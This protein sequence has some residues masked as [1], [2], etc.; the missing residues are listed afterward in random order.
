MEGRDGCCK[1]QHRGEFH[2]QQIGPE[3]ADA[4][5]L[6]VDRGVTDTSAGRIGEQH[7]Q[8]LGQQ[9]RAEDDRTDP[10][11]GFEPGT[12][13]LNRGRAQ[14]QHHHHKH[15]Q[16]H[17]RARIGNDFQHTGERRAEAEERH[18]YSDQRDDQVEQGVHRIRV[19]DH[20]QGGHNSDTGCEV[21]S[22]FHLY[23][24][25]AASS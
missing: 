23:F 14:V 7:V 12:F 17:D 19:G 22:E 1:Q 6:G 11:A 10:D 20:P 9:Q 8:Q 13:L 18:C 24:L 15:E 3:Q 2:H 4:D 16:D 21:E 25:K 5:C